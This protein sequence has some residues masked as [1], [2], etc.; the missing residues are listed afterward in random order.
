MNRLEAMLNRE[1][2]DFVTVRS[3]LNRK[4]AQ[5]VSQ[6][7]ADYLK[8]GG[9]ITQVPPGKSGLG[10]FAAKRTQEPVRDAMRQADYRRSGL[11]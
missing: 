4:E 10:D 7:V 5:E 11:V 6:Q 1:Q 8:A 3:G 2:T 9:K